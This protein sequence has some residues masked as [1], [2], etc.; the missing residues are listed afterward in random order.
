MTSNEPALKICAYC[1][2]EKVRVWSGAKL[3]DGSKVFIDHKHQRWAGRRC[4]DCEKARVQTAVK[5]DRFAKANILRELEAKGFEVVSS[6]VP[7]KVKKDGN[8]FTVGMRRAFMDGQNIVVDN[9]GE[10]GVDMVA[11]VFETVRL[12]IPEQIAAMPNIRT[13]AASAEENPLAIPEGSATGVKSP[14]P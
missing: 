11:L 14:T 13:L 5:C 12:F 4:P 6:A 3:K 9:E 1:E 2:Q 10:T 8:E 7:I